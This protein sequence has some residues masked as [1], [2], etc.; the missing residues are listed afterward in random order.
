MDYYTAMQLA[1]MEAVLH[2]TM[3]S[4]SR[5][6]CRWYSREFATPLHEAY[7]LPFE[8]VLQAYYEASYEN[9]PEE[10]RQ[11]E[12]DRLLETDD[13]KAQRLEAE[14][15]DEKSEDE[16]A[17]ALEKAVQEDAKK[18]KIVEPKGRKKPSLPGKLSLPAQE[19]KTVTS[20]PEQAEDVDIAE[21]TLIDM[22][23]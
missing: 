7:E 4:F 13:E 5:S 22:K 21:E 15:A 6:I 23:F 14:K 20:L 8:D 19:V 12:L 1:A 10:E 17:A 3:E 16:L 9:M 18:G 11:I 2:P